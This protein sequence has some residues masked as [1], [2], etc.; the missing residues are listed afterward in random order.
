MEI[1]NLSS[2]E[3][4]IRNNN[5]ELPSSIRGIIVGKSGCGKTNLLINL[6]LKDNILDYDNLMIYGKSLFQ[7]EYEL[8]KK[9][10]EFP[11]DAVLKLF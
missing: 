7:D 5:P 8:L 1:E 6:L 2:R 11:K 3:K 10:E 4:V 9:L